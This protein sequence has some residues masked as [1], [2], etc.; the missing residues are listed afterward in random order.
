MRRVNLGFDADIEQ[1]AAGLASA[2]RPGSKV[3]LAGDGTIAVRRGPL[4]R[5]VATLHQTPDGAAIEVRGD[6]GG[7]PLP[8]AAA[9]LRWV[10][11]RTVTTEV[12][13]AV[14]ASHGDSG[15]DRDSVPRP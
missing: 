10:G 8:V 9:V 11:E 5:C 14:Q 12:A 7:V 13:A 15:A 1:V 3:E 2:L 6:D 4:R